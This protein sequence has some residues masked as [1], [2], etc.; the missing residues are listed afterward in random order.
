MTTALVTYKRKAY[1]DRWGHKHP[2]MI[3]KRRTSADGKK[4]R[5]RRKKRTSKEKRWYAPKVRSGWEKGMPAKKRRRL[6]LSAHKGSLLSAARSKQALANVTQDE[7]TKV[8]ALEDAQFFFR[9]HK[10]S[11]R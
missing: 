7:E 3:V 1:V 10:K 5:K 2:A 8:L 4:K 11:K 6:T 9:E